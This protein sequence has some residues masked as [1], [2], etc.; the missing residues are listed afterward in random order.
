MDAEAGWSR[1][2]SQRFYFDKNVIN[3]STLLRQDNHI[4]RQLK[5]MGQKF[6]FVC[7]GK[8]LFYVGDKPKP[9]FLDKSTVAELKI[10]NYER[11][12]LGVV[13]NTA[14]YAIMTPVNISIEDAVLPSNHYFEDLRTLATNI[15]PL[16][17]SYLA[18][19]KAL[20]Y[21][22]EKSRFCG[23]C[24]SP[25]TSQKNGH[26]RICSDDV[27]RQV[28]FPR[29]DPAVIMLVTHPT[30]KKCLL[31]RN[32]RF[33]GMRFST[34]AGFVEPGETLEQAVI[35][36]VFEETGVL[37]SKAKYRGSQPWPFPASI[38]LGFRAEADSEEIKCDD[39]ELIEARWF[40]KE[41]TLALSKLEDGLPP[42]NFS[43]S[44][45]L[46]DVWLNEP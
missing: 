21:W 31:G 26:E 17:A 46:I 44:R 33:K 1:I 24:G 19:A 29:T 35:R 12:F 43:I 20:V 36:E 28:H 39:D 23:T 4:G 13:D 34:L 7:D 16:E 9:V 14:F 25:T 27:C 8:N 32:R 5:N 38:M 3:R 45:W 22:N 40:T 11:V 30:A 42:S 41:E 2:M 6:I 18:Y 15:D 10:E 37:V